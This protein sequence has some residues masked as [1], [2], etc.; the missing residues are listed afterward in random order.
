MIVHLVTYTRTSSN[1]TEVVFS[2]Y[3][4]LPERTLYLK[5]EGKETIALTYET[6]E[7]TKYIKYNVVYFTEEDVDKTIN[8]YVG[9]T[10]PKKQ[11]KRALRSRRVLVC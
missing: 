7:G 1:Y 2:N 3:A 9:T 6:G 10:P 8:I 11:I 4:S 5:R